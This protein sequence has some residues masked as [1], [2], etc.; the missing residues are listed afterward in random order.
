MKQLFRRLWS[1]HT[2]EMSSSITAL[3]LIGNSRKR[4]FARSS[5][6]IA[7]IALISL[8]IAT[9]TILL[10]HDVID[11]THGDPQK[12]CKS[13]LGI[14]NRWVHCDKTCPLGYT[15]ASSSCPLSSSNGSITGGFKTVFNN[16]DLVCDLDDFHST[17]VMEWDA[18]IPYFRFGAFP[19]GDP[20][21]SVTAL[22]AAQGAVVCQ[23]FD[24]GTDNAVGDPYL[25][26]L[27]QIRSENGLTVSVCN[28]GAASCADGGPVPVAPVT[29]R[30]TFS[31]DVLQGP[32]NE[33]L[34]WRLVP[35]TVEGR[36]ALCKD[37]NDNPIPVANCAANFGL[38]EHNGAT[39]TS[40]IANGGGSG[41]SRN[42]YP[43]RD[44]TGDG[45]NDLAN[46]Q[47]FKF[48]TETQDSIERPKSLFWG[49]CHNG[50]FDNRVATACTFGN[51]RAAKSTRAAGEVEGGLIV[52][53]DI[54]PGTATNT[55]NVGNTS[56][57]S[58][59][60]VA[61][62]GSASLPI[63]VGSVP[64][65]VTVGANS[66]VF[67]N[68]TEVAVNDFFISDTNSD[69][70]ND[71]VINFNRASFIGAV[72]P[73]NDGSITVFF[74]G[75]LNDSPPTNWQGTDVL[76]VNHCSSVGP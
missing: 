23:E 12:S 63:S 51:G 24:H 46:G 41:E 70:F 26:T 20:N 59:F 72:T 71:L 34:L 8:G 69:T 33:N 22:N 13:S 76:T 73:C 40:G 3:S 74:N 37:Q 53:V 2:L 66:G 44:L 54:Q 38:D 1:T 56:D 7:T 9:P 55:L 18:S 64:F 17:A 65:N 4:K 27:I 25:F 58:S 52:A 10:A 11:Q 32:R 68:G 49:P 5:V 16:H 19:D 67:V 30:T 50:Q 28:Q 35:A 15:Q 57:T 75:T 43:A 47:V 61:I 29:Q 31:F 6:V 42:D 14:I 45:I 60:P 36:N 39:F 48:T 21:T 62:L